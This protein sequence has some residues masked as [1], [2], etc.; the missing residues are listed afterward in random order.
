MAMLLTAIVV[1]GYDSMP[2]LGIV[3]LKY[4]QMEWNLFHSIT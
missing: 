3:C 1:L 4:D 2:L